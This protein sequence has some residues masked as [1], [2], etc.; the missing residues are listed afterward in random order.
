MAKF[1]VMFLLGLFNVTATVDMN[2]TRILWRFGRVISVISVGT[3][4]VMEILANTFI[5]L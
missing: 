2:Y 4:F 5:Q 1:L 3:S